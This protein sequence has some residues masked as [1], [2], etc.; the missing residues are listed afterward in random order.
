V[1]FLIDQGHKSVVP[2]LC[3]SLCTK[4]GDNFKLASAEVI[5][6]ESVLQHCLQFA[7]TNILRGLMMKSFDAH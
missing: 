6:A 2:E 3:T 1:N 5:K 4:Y 7:E